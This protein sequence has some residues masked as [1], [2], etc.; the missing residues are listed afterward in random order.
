MRRIASLAALSLVVGALTA[1]FAPHH[2][3]LIIRVELVVLAGIFVSATVL[4]LRTMFPEV[5]L[6]PFGRR[7]TRRTNDLPVDFERVR[8]DVRLASG[9]ATSID[10]L[11]VPR[12]RAIAA[13]RLRHHGVNLDDPADAGRGEHLCGPALWFLARPDRV[14]SYDAT[15]P[16]IEPAT[17][18]EVLTRLETL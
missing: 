9:S 8:I 16:G 2:I 18:D 17:L 12:V 5:D 7:R 10:R 11:L 3:V 15:D 6:G 4:T 1:T 13:V 14:V